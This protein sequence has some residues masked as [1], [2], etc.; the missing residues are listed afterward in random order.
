MLL[1]DDYNQHY[2]AI[3]VHSF[4]HTLSDSLALTYNTVSYSAAISG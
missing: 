4:T 2:Y 1:A 3:Q